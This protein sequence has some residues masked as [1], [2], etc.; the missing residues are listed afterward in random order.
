MKLTLK[1]FPSV[2]RYQSIC[3]AGYL[4]RIHPHNLGHI[5][6]RKNFNGRISEALGEKSHSAKNATVA[7]ALPEARLNS[8]RIQ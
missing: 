8:L 6:T 5:G 1:W 2:G 3:A 7:T 4:D